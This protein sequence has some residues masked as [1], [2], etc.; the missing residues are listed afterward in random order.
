MLFKLLVFMCPEQANACPTRTEQ[1]RRGEEL[2][3]TCLHLGHGGRL[4]DGELTHN[5][6]NCDHV[7]PPALQEPRFLLVFVRPLTQVTQ[8]DKTQPIIVFVQE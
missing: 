8:D 2:K 7:L 4:R 5:E 3:K 1:R 6:G